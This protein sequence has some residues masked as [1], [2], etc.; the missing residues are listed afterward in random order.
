MIRKAKLD[1]L[2]KLKNI[3]NHAVLH[4]V[5]TFDTEIKDDANRMQWFLEHE[6]YPYV[7]Y[8]VPL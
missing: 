6:E 1:D 4:T 2:E 5:A 3:Y 8:D 7:R